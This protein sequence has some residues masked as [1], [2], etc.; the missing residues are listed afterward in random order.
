MKKM[1]TYRNVIKKYVDVNFSDYDYFMVIDT[2]ASGGF[3]LNGL[4]YSFGI[5]NNWDMMSAYG[6]TGL[7]L[8]LGKLVYHDYIAL[9]NDISYNSIK[10]SIKINLINK[11]DGLIPVDNAFGGLTIYKMSSIKNVDYTPHDDKYICEHTI[12]SN[13][14]K[15][16][17]YNKFY[18]NPK[19]VFLVGKQG[20]SYLFFY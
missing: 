3:S 18:I 8:T 1:S 4:A 7:V 11:N 16:N 5:N 13:N 12:F 19:L 17:G 2:D 15:M 6:L 14:M 20:D 10:D 9:C